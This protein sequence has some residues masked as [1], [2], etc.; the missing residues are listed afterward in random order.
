MSFLVI[1]VRWLAE[2]PA[3]AYHGQE[4]PPSP[5]RLFSALVAGSH[6]R[7]VAD[8][9]HD[10]ALRYLAGLREAPPRI[11]VPASQLCSPV[12]T[13]VPN[14]DYDIVMEKAKR[15]GQAYADRVAPSY[16]T[17]RSRQGRAVPDSIRYVW[18]VDDDACKHADALQS[19]AR[20]LTALGQGMD[21]ACATV[22]IQEQLPVS[23]GMVYKPNENGQTF[24]ALPHS[25]TL[26]ALFGREDRRR[27]SIEAE[28]PRRGAPPPAIH[29]SPEV[30]VASVAYQGPRDLPRRSS[31]VF[32]LL[33]PSRQRRWSAQPG[34]GMEPAAMTRHAIAQAAR[35]TGLDAQQRGELLGH[36]GAG[37]V[38][39]VPLPNAGH[40]WAD[41]HYRR[42]ML[43]AND[44]VP[45][46]HWESL[47]G[48][49]AM[50]DL[51]PEG[52]ADPAAVLVSQSASV[53]NVADR[54][55]K[56]RAG[57]TT[58]E[59]ATPVILPCHL[60]R[61]GKPRPERTMRRILQQSG[62][63][64][65]MVESVRFHH[66]PRVTGAD[67]PMNYQVPRHLQHFHRIHL[68]IRFREPVSGPILLGAGVGWG[69]G[70]FVVPD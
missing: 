56:K 26:E 33:D 12:K 58:W 39:A 40:C 1:T 64:E 42:L 45:D 18:R 60:Y 28:S 23:E 35:A 46:R 57:S 10:A 29:S 16:N 11:E 34:T 37:R 15:E 32:D 41:G 13:A 52:Q 62:Y 43:V 5:H 19:L 44:G 7:G 27:Q 17:V 61:R 63:P 20:N 36:G 3:P 14:N 70:L 9:D 65:E 6:G 31:V 67:H 30:D 47:Q 51:V 66:D 55:L 68:T 49:V 59:S 38:H 69:I 2:P 25:D 24:L 54:Y 53:D 50:Q 4:W 21:L 8:N 48:R 22:T